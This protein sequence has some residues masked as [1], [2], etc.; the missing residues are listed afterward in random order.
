[1]NQ[2]QLNEMLYQ[3]IETEQGGQRIYTQANQSADH[4]EQKK[5]WDKYHAQGGGVSLYPTRPIGPPSAVTG[6]RPWLDPPRTSPSIC[7][8]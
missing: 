3:A 2:D 4:Q 1:M 7:R 8:P 6:R 5:E